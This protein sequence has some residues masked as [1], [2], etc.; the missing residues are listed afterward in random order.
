MSQHAAARGLCFAPPVR[1]R[2]VVPRMKMLRN[3]AD[4]EADHRRF[5]ERIVRSETV[6][7]LKGRNG[8]AWCESNDHEG[9]DVIVFWSDRAYTERA[10]KSEFQEYTPIEISLFDF[11]FRWLPGMS[12][13]G[14]LAGTNWTGNLIG[15]ESDPLE[16]QDQV[17][18]HMPKEMVSLFMEKLKKGIAA[19]GKQI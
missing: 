7:A 2:P 10:R 17:I 12:N 9:R 3:R 8:Y 13:D 5:I 11:L 6:W 19:Q 1:R 4:S 15:I 14:V 16:L 18:N